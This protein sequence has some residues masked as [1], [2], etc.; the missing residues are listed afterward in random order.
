MVSSNHP[1]LR[2]KSLAFPHAEF[3]YHIEGLLGSFSLLLPNHRP[4]KPHMSLKM[5]QTPRLDAVVLATHSQAMEPPE[6]SLAVAHSQAKSDC[7][8]PH[9][10]R[11]S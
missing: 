4:S 5:T 11:G 7:T 8:K 2:Q 10:H 1:Y 9:P 6:L 3:P